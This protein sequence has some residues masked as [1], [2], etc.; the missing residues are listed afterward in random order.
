MHYVG[1]MWLDVKH[2][3]GQPAVGLIGV[4][5]AY[6]W[7]ERLEL[8]ASV[9]NL[10]NVA[11]CDNATTSVSGRILGLPRSWSGGLQWAL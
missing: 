8:R 7:S 11:Y 6:R 5:A 9:S 4:S 1:K 3:I 10:T 2:T